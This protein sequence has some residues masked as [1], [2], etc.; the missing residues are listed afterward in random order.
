MLLLLTTIAALVAGIGIGFA[1]SRRG[2]LPSHDRERIASLLRFRTAMDA[3]QDSVYLTDHETMRF[4][5]VNQKA[6]SR[7]GYSRD[8]LLT[9][10]PMD[11]VQAPRDEI[12]RAYDAVIAAGEAGLCF[13]V[14]NVLKHGVTSV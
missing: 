8:E 4:I 14:T 11:L 3:S 7:T 1:A 13:E 6:T 10:G 5:D 2:L 12:Q 9:M